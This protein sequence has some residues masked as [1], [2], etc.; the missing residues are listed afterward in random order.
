MKPIMN[1]T[2]AVKTEAKVNPSSASIIVI[3]MLCIIFGANTVAVKISLNGFGPFTNAGIR[4]FIATM[5]ICM[6][7]F[8][9]NRPLKL[10]KKQWPSVI[11]ISL[12]FFTQIVLV[13]FGMEKTLASR[14]ALISNLQPF[15][16][17][18]FAHFFIISDRITIKKLTGII[19]GFVGA[20]FIFFGKNSITS[21]VRT[22]DLMI[23]AST[24][25]WALN[26]VYTKKVIHN[27]RPYQLAALPGLLCIPFFFIGGAL[28]DGEMIK[29][30][31]VNV[32]M[33]MLYQSLITASIG[34]IL[35]ISMLKKFGAVTLHS[36]I[37]LMPIAGVF[38]GGLILNEPIATLNILLALIFIIAGVVVVHSS[39]D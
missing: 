10:S 20:G 6:W 13:Y 9:T 35:W 39:I 12:L 18:I 15:F 16:V 22:G 36:Y 24:I 4:F 31:D 34:Y 14:C 26:G 29:T 37:F 11:V 32:I 17:L 21:D 2:G 23:F 7:A 19:L 3:A 1:Y 5:A 27:Y 38:F 25:I 8:L 28:F 33:A 30:I